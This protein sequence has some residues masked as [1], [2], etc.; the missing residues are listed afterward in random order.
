[1][2]VLDGGWSMP[3]FSLMDE[4]PARAE[5][6]EVRRRD[7][8]RHGP[9]PS[10]TKD[11]VPTPGGWALILVVTGALA[12]ALWQAAGDEAGFAWLVLSTVLGY[13]VAMAA[14][15]AVRLVRDARADR[16]EAK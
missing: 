5:V 6:F 10:E 11:F 14:W 3:E 9:L 1:M 15:G 7:C 12:W 4:T 2:S 13:A 16:R 8:G